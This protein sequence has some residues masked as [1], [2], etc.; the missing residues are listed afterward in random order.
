MGDRRPQLWN[1]VP[2]PSGGKAPPPPTP[3]G[4][5]CQ[6]TVPPHPRGNRPTT[7]H[8]HCG[9]RLGRNRCCQ[10]FG[11]PL[12]L[13]N[14]A[15]GMQLVPTTVS[16]TPHTTGALC[17]Q[18][19]RRNSNHTRPRGV[20]SGSISKK[21]IQNVLPKCRGYKWP[22]LTAHGPSRQHSDPQQNFR[23]DQVTVPPPPREG[24][25]GGG[26]G[27]PHITDSPP[28]S[29]SAETSVPKADKQPELFSR[30]E[31]LCA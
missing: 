8:T 25:V 14:V 24:P 23:V 16:H 29:A 2:L 21:V 15:C 9:R 30:P 6:V 10:V 18:S 19:L 20:L 3:P 26:G 4:D 12:A 7:R 1:V 17:P 31:P 5:G 22:C 28:F 11:N 27:Y 13:G